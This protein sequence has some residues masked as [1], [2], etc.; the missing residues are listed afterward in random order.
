MQIYVV[1]V[2][3]AT[4]QLVQQGLDELAI[5]VSPVRGRL[6]LHCCLESSLR[7]RPCCDCGSVSSV[8]VLYNTATSMASS[9]GCR[10]DGCRRHTAA[11]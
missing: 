5:L 2:D 7:C 4:G 10:Q 11:C 6:L 3:E 1:V 9:M 8:L